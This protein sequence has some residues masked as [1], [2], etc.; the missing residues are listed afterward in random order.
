MIY[1]GAPI[2]NI[3]Y[4][5]IQYIACCKCRVQIAER[6]IRNHQHTGMC[7]VLFGGL[8][9]SKLNHPKTPLLCPFLK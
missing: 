9:Q 5:Y 8:A 3:G 4:T 1:I 7:M 2:Y 6:K